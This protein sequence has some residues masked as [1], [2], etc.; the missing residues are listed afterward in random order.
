MYSEKS[1]KSK[2]KIV[3]KIF[4]LVFIVCFFMPFVTVS[5][6]SEEHTAKGY[7]I[8]I[9]EFEDREIQKHDFSPNLFIAIPMACALLSELLLLWRYPP[10]VIITVFQFVSIICLALFKVTFC[11]FY[12]FEDL[13]VLTLDLKFRSYYWFSIVLQLVCVIFGLVYLREND[14]VPALEESNECSDY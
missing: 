6:S 4:L 7:E 10:K 13:S 14:Y 12:N 8:A 3:F 11:D 2:V 5:C 1:S 9:G